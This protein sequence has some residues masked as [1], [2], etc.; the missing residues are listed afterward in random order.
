MKRVRA[1]AVVLSMLFVATTARADDDEDA[2]AAMRRGVAAFGR[3]EAEKALEE[4]ETAKK[5]VPLANA[6]YLYA[7]E[8]LVALARYKEAVQ[9][10]EAYLAKSPNVSDAEDV[11]TRIARIKAE[12]YLGR[13]KI[14]SN[15]AEATVELDNSPKGDV[16]DLELEPGKHRV[17]LR[18]PGRVAAAQDI[19]VVGDRDATLVFTLAEEQ[20]VEPPPRPPPPEPTTSPWRTAGFV[21]TGVGAA[22]LLVTFIV[23]AAALGPKISDYRAAAD[24]GDPQ[25]R[26]LHDDAVGLRN[27]AIAGYVVGGVVTAAGLGIVLFGPRTTTNVA[28]TPW[29]TPYAGGLGIRS[30]L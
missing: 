7:A 27:G 20:K 29:A 17:E 9:N 12:H 18:A 25:A 26:S 15:V 21:A 5:L 19:Q 24:R 3:G 23:D 8:A 16:R 14:V 10:L 1:I 13:V 30:S 6:P 2:R 11:R 4:Y 28:I 22:T